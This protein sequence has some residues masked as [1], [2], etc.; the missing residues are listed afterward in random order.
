[1]KTADVLFVSNKTKGVQF[2]KRLA[3]RNPLFICVLGTTETAKIPNISVAG[4]NPNLTDYTPSADA[5]ILLLGKCKSIEQIPVTPEGIP[6]PAIITHSAL[7]LSNIPFLIVDAGSRIK[8]KVPF[9]NLNGNYGKDIR[10]GKACKDAP[11][12]FQNAKT[13]G[14]QLYKFAG[15]LVIGESIPGGTTTSLAILL[16][17]GIDAI[18]K[19]SSSMSVNPHKLKTEVAKTALKTAKI[20]IGSL[21]DKPI[22]TVSKVGDPVLAAVAGLAVGAAGNIPVMLAGGTQ[23]GAVLSLIHKIKPNVLQNIAIGTTRWLAQD[24]MSDLVGIVKQ[25]SDV[26]ILAAN[27]D[28][29]SSRFE[30]LRAYE[31]GVVKEGVGAGGAVIA[32]IM[33]KSVTIETVLKSIEEHYAKLIMDG[34]RL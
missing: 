17:L 4:K 13:F 23:M 15:Y 25:I 19:V 3:S 22:E 32:A 24:P 28:F 18:G 33:N 1:M 34:N 21:S 14:G 12:I 29:S 16:A 31:K 20:E 2:A 26:P 27:L 6:T 7:Q 5:E 9:V 8:P 30:G 11:E 10:N